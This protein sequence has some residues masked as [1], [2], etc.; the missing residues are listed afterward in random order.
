M[1][2]FP[3]GILSAAGAGGVASDYELI[4]S[5][6]LGSNQTSVTFSS[7]GDYSSTYKHLQIRYVAR[8]SRASVFDGGRL[9]LNG[10][11]GAN[12]DDHGLYGTGSIVGSFAQL[13][14]STGINFGNTPGANAAADV[15]GPGVIDILDSFSS[16]KFK[17]IRELSGVNSS[18]PSVALVSGSWRNTNSITTI[19][20]SPNVGPNWVAGSRFS[21][22][23]IK[24]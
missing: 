17:V 3:L 10:D 18:S 4:Q 1:L 5:Y 11:T 19:A 6:I 7:L 24:G 20:I 15:Y 8:T 16:T 12:F 9:R 23:G 21:L 14:A 2:G 13:N 22:Y